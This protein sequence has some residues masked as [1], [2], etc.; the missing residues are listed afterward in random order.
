V[1]VVVGALVAGAVV[2]CAGAALVGPGLLVWAVVLGAGLVGASVE[3]G[4]VA[5]GLAG[6]VLVTGAGPSLGADDGTG[7]VVVG[8]GSLSAAPLA[9]TTRFWIC[10]WKVS[11]RS[12]IW[13]R[14][15]SW[16]VAAKA[17]I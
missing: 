15:R 2:V 14:G 1:E 10:S 6:W 12:R 17:P 5:V 13:S 8:V 3:A 11:R 7:A 4:R 9:W 16:M